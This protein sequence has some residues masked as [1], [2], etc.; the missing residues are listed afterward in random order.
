MTVTAKHN[1]G[2]A[3]ARLAHAGG[4]P[5]CLSLTQATMPQ[6]LSKA[7]STS[8]RKKS[9][10][11]RRRRATATT[12]KGSRAKDHGGNHEADEDG[13][14]DFVGQGARGVGWGP[15]ALLGACCVLFSRQSRLH[16][17]RPERPLPPGSG[18]KLRRVQRV[19]RL[20]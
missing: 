5:L 12:V 20:R 3:L 17:C 2:E 16:S 4:A 18:S 14:G 11:S 6:S 15:V 8:K 19:R 7:R 13:G 10:K 9:G 1:L